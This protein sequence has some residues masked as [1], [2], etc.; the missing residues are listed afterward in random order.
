M[1][2]TLTSLGDGAVQKMTIV[3]TGGDGWG[4]P[5]DEYYSNALDR[6]DFNIVEVC[7]GDGEFV[8]LCDL[9]GNVIE[10]TPDNWEMVD[11]KDIPADVEK[12]VLEGWSSGTA[13]VEKDD[14]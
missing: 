9:D 14:E 7:R 8:C 2:F 4:D 10:P 5:G 1:R 6:Y 3:S 11:D 13:F 12:A